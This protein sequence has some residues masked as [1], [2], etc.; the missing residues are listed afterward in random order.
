MSHQAEDLS[1]IDGGGPA[2]G[3]LIG[4][5]IDGRYQIERILGEGGMGLVYQVLHVA[6]NKKFA[7]KVLR[8]DVSRDA[9]IIER[10]KRE[11]QSA[12]AIGN[13]HI[14]DI[15][16]FGKLP[17]GSTYFIMEFLEGQDLTAAIEDR[18]N[19]I[20]AK[21]MIH[22]G[23][24]LCDALSAAHNAG[25]VHRDLK[26]DNI[27]L[28]TRGKNTDFVKVLDFGIAKAG[29]GSSKLTR[30]G[31]VFGTP[32]YM[33]PEQCSGTD[34]DH[35]TDIYA[36]GV[37]FY[38]MLAGQVPFDA[39]NLMGILSKHLYEQPRPLRELAPDVPESLEHIVGRAMA[40]N[41]DERYQTMD[42][43]ADDLRR[44]QQGLA[45]VPHYFA[46]TLAPGALFGGG[47]ATGSEK[48]KPPIAVIAV[49]A[50]A[51]ILG[52]AGVVM[53]LGGGDEADA[54]RI[55]EASEPAPELE[56]TPPPEAAP[57]QSAQEPEPMVIRTVELITDPENAEIW[58]G[59]SLVGN[60]PLDLP[61]PPEGEEPADYELRYPGYQPRSFSISSATIAKRISFKLEP[62]P[63]PKPAASTR[64]TTM[65]AT[66]MSSSASSSQMST[67]T[68]PS[69][70]SSTKRSTVGLEVLDPW[71]N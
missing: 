34:V 65:R 15:S 53:F 23:L 13:Q 39:D 37:I 14:I 58:S 41:A 28:I 44:V 54:E 57:E 35:R 36:L 6:L 70:M 67:T 64:T 17:D 61:V 50:L 66:T 12:T 68:Q 59:E 52:G 62:V 48:K 46:K 24:Q 47:D 9:E 32:H 25:I 30:A 1:V 11:A 63:A 42:E 19:P 10:F 22:I 8:A 38:E 43:L 31:Q 56:A 18:D 45:P 49:A 33:S 2:D 51:L 20:D 40:K 7:M 16:D 3:S 69:T 21:R 26:P 4:E 29:G 71:A 55:V 5:T 60:S 27:F